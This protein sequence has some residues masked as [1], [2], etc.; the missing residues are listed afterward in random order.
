MRYKRVL[1]ADSGALGTGP[2]KLSKVNVCGLSAGSTLTLSDSS[3]VGSTASIA[4]ID[5]G[6]IASYD[7]GSV[8]LSNGLYYVLAGGAGAKPDVTIVWE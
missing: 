7:F 1:A 5:C 2:S 8:L 6:T 3:V 4:V